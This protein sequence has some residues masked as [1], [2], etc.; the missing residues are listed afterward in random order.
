MKLFNKLFSYKQEFKNYKIHTIA[1]FFGIKLSFYQNLKAPNKNDFINYI[2]NHQKDR[3]NFV[4]ITKE[5]Y[6]RKENDP[7]LVAFYLPQ[8]H[9]FPE[10]DR[11]FGR[12]FS[13]W[14]NSS[15]ALPQYIG[16]YQPH[17]PIDTGFYNLETTEIM[18]RQIE[19]AKMYGIYGFS[20]YYYW[21]SGH[22]VMEKPIEMF[23]ADKSLD[24]PFFMFWANEPWTKLWGDGGQNEILFEHE[25]NDGDDVK[26]MNDILPYMKDKRYIKIDNK[27]L[28]VIY[29]PERYELKK[30]TNF[31]VGIR[32]IAKENGFSDLYIMMPR[33]A[34]IPKEKMQSTLDKYKLDAI[35]EFLPHN[36]SY[37]EYKPKFEKVANKKFLGEIYDVED[38]VKNK[39]Y[40]YKTDCKVFKGLYP[41]WDNTARKCYTGSWI[42]QST[43]KL[44]KA[45]LKD[46]IN[47]TKENNSKA[48][49]FIFINAWN[50]W[51]EGAHLEPDQKYGYAYLQETK[52]ALEETKD[53]KI[54]K[55]FN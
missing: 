23:L 38:Y 13:E 39:K 1:R 53:C 17:L 51:A 3:S 31:I 7:K 44:Y 20:F 26:F 45:W 24:M 55:I 19:L 14:S 16:H 6:K 36:I 42:F 40:I 33:K 2:L 5:P 48:E 37:Q 12:G 4:Q 46:I 27:P 47:W 35:I 10:N 41:N 28:L 15:K 21:F 54:A 22:K 11:W 29:N 30:L 18:K 25:I 52:D 34:Q 9:S 50:E 43:P 49:Q 8:F 32:Q